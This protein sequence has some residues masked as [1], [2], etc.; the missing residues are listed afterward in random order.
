MQERDTVD[1]KP[2]LKAAVLRQDV[3]RDSMQQRYPYL[4]AVAL[5][6]LS[7]R[8][9]TCMSERN[10]SLSWYTNPN[11]RH[12]LGQK[13]VTEKLLQTKITFEVGL[14][15]TP[16]LQ[17]SRGRLVTAGQNADFPLCLGNAKAQAAGQLGGA[18]QGDAA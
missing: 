17:R 10:R 16:V 5:R 18:G 2:V 1:G 8:A 12:R 11:I 3:W 14:F 13:K 9:T 4:A 6:L 15:C 7:L